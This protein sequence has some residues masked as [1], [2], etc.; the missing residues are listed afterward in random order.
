M[1]RRHNRYIQAAYSVALASPGAGGKNGRFRL[2]AI[3]V[4]KKAIIAANFNSLKTNP[5]LC[6]F[7]EYPHTHAEAGAILS[8][9]L[10]NC[11]DKILYV[12]RIRRDNTLAM[13]K[14]CGECQK[15]IQH[16]GIKKV[17]YSTSNGVVE[18]SCH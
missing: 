7:Y 11:R 4:D 8:A 3:L 6:A 16:V 18:L 15:L 14:P 9:G 12:V 5:K 1:K 17:F 10:N 13:A 2:G